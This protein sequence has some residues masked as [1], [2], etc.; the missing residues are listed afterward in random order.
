M[1]MCAS[2]HLGSTGT[3]SETL[4]QCWGDAGP[5]H[6]ELSA[7]TKYCSG[8]C[9]VRHPSIFIRTDT[10]I[11]KH[12]YYNVEVCDKTWKTCSLNWDMCES[13]WN[14]GGSGP[15]NLRPRPNADWPSSQS[16]LGQ[17]DAFAG[18][19]THEITDF[20]ASGRNYYENMSLWY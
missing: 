12:T 13:E 15:V 6:I 20:L 8:P 18:R 19:V 14:L 16:S 5:S 3:A 7:S 11:C 9:C 4:V 17:G 2:Q 10:P 1:V